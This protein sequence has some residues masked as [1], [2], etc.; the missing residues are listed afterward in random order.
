MT[1]SIM[2]YIQLYKCQHSMAPGHQAE[3]CKPVPYIDAKRHLQ[4]A[5]CTQLDIP[6][7]SSQI[8]NIRRMRVMLCQLTLFLTS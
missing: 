6:R 8:V 7:V 5:G 2:L 3:L 4:S 1:S